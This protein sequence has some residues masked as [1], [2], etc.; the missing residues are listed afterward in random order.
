[1]HPIARRATLLMATA[2]LLPLPA[3]AQGTGDDAPYIDS[4]GPVG[5]ADDTATFNAALR[6]GKGFRLRAT[7]YKVAGPVLAQNVAVHMHGVP[8]ASRI[9][10]T[11]LQAGSWFRIDTK[12][13]IDISGVIWDGGGAHTGADAGMV[14]IVGAPAAC[15]LRQCG[16]L[17]GSGPTGLLI[18]VAADGGEEALMV[19]DQIEAARNGGSGIWIEHGANWRLSGL[20]LHDN[21]GAGIQCH[22]FGTRTGAPLKRLTIADSF[23]WK[24][25]Q[26]G[27]AIGNYNEAPGG[28]KMVLGPNLPDVV[29]ATLVNLYSW[30]NGGYGIYADAENLRLTGCRTRANW[31]NGGIDANAR[32]CTIEDCE[33]SNER[34]FGIDTGGAYEVR[35]SRCRV[36]DIEGAGI[37]P[38]G[39]YL[40]TGSDNIVLGCTG[41][42]VAIWNTEYGGGWFQYQM[43]HLRFTNTTLDISR[44]KAGHAIEVRDGARDIVFDGL[45]IISSGP[46]APGPERVLYAAT[47]TITVRHARFNGAGR[48][49]VAPQGGVLT[50][51]DIADAVVLPP[52][53]QTLTQ[54]RTASMASVGTGIGWIA[55]DEP[56]TGYDPTASTAVLEGDGDVAGVGKLVPN[57]WT[58]GGGRLI[59][60]RL[61]APG[62]NFTRAAVR[63]GGPGTGAKVRVQLGIPLPSE[64]RLTLFFPDGGRLAGLLPAVAVNAGGV[65]ELVELNGKWSLAAHG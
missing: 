65:V 15:T 50:V 4:F 52:G 27:F 38:G 59:G 12:E 22:R 20:R 7:S 47:A 51:P 44:L 18:A 56:G 1:M 3:M 13:V 30:G 48:I 11:G 16:V 57:V 29:E 61:S 28:Q 40:I 24:N 54:V 36:T 43:N 19:L 37:N 10:G 41:P 32:H 14:S 49:T 42:A 5:G 63:L 58:G 23:A 26:S 25:G 45:D 55:V 35:I 2:A 39:S 21:K 31:E 9:V 8:G 53:L 6:S 33:V 34:G 62:K 17:R 46:G 64:R 60:F